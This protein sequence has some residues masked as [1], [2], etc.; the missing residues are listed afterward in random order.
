MRAYSPGPALLT[1][2]VHSELHYRLANFEAAV[3]YVESGRL[4]Q[5]VR[6]SQ[7]AR[8]QASNAASASSANAS[9]PKRRARPRMSSISIQS[10][11]TL[12]LLLTPQSSSSSRRNLFN[13]DAAAPSGV[14]SGAGT[15]NSSVANSRRASTDGSNALLAE[16]LATNADA[17]AIAA[18]GGEEEEEEE[19]HSMFDADVEGL[20]E[21]DEEDACIDPR[22]I[23]SAFARFGAGDAATDGAHAD[24]VCSDG[25][26]PDLFAR[27]SAGRALRRSSR[28]A[29][30]LFHQ[31]R[32]AASG[33]EGSAAVASSGNAAA[34]AASLFG[35]SIPEPDSLLGNGAS[36]PA[37]LTGAS[38]DG[39]AATH[40]SPSR[41]RSP[42][43]APLVVAT[44]DSR[45]PTGRTRSDTVVRA[46]M[47]PFLPRALSSSAIAATASAACG[48]AAAAGA[49]ASSS[50]PS[51]ASASCSGGPSSPA[52]LSPSLA[53]LPSHPSW[54]SSV[55]SSPLVPLREALDEDDLDPLGALTRTKK[56]NKAN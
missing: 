19:E 27:A 17:A 21:E 54:S 5:H 56:P 45:I 24:G 7:A 14:C 36:L 48:T 30:P 35:C 29:E 4:L 51:M 15:A 13:G 10:T 8:E 44:G 43:A 20:D 11:R 9:G 18:A 50:S 3:S 16:A 52:A 23:G 46:P 12:H 22:L 25:D 26:M 6:E 38:T 32:R 33:G 1:A 34:A 28:S 39:A 49:V 41:S 40:S 53:P 2:S 37:W 42:V 31:A 55:L 47:A